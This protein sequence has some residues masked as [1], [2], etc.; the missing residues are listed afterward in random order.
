[1]EYAFFFPPSF[2]SESVPERSHP[3]EAREA[4][5]NQ[6]NTIS[7]TQTHLR[8]Q[9]PPTHRQ[10]EHKASTFHRLP[11]GRHTEDVCHMA[12]YSLLWCTTFDQGRVK[13]KAL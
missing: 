1:M 9:N 8:T 3:K 2:S 13:K 6:K 5:W 7:N 12:P 10:V 4:A 11:A